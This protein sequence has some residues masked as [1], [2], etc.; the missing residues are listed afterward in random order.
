MI[1]MTYL[2]QNF[3]K[4]KKLLF[5][6]TLLFSFLLIS[7]STD[8]GNNSSTTNPVDV[9]VAGSKNEQACY[10]KNGQEV[11]LNDGLGA[12]ADSVFVSNCDVHVFG[13]KYFDNFTEQDL[14]WK[15][16]VL[17]NLT[18]TLSTPDQ[19]V[20]KI[21]GYDV[22]GDDVYVVG[23]TKNPLIAAEIYDLVYWKNGIKTVVA[24]ANNPTY[25]STIKVVN[26]SVYIT[27]NTLNCFDVCNG[28]YV[29]GVFQPTTIGKVVYDFT[30]KNNEIYVYGTDFVQNS[31]FYKNLSTNLETNNPLIHRNI[32]LIFDN[33]DV[34]I[35]N[36]SSIYKNNNIIYESSFFSFYIDFTALN[37]NVYIL[38]REGDFGTTDV[39]YINNIN[40]LQTFIGEGKFNSIAVV[41]K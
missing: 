37:E 31:V 19:M 6:S 3:Y 1:K 17:T 9:Y 26:N 15:N 10:W 11:L 24:P 29:N 16:N 5:I 20:K 38:K 8:T 12:E 22:V 21:T 35:S 27:G 32:K 33:N 4:M 2:N 34:Y 7:C 25:K 18:Q 23:Y 14:Y 41:Q 28:I 39:L 13:T 40:V 30:I 36:G